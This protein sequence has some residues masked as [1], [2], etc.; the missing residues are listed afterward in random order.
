[1]TKAGEYWEED[2][3]ASFVDHSRDALIRSIDRSLALLGRIDVLQIHKA[4]RPVL[5]HPDVQAALDH[6]ASCGILAFGASVSDCDA[7]LA[8]VEAGRYETV[9]FPLNAANRTLLP[10]LPDLAR[11]S[12]LPVVNRPFAMGALVSGKSFDAAAFE[13]FAFLRA[14]VERGIVLTGTGKAAHLREN[15]RAFRSGMRA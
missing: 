3:R 8:A 14:H 10:L 13:A 1:M 6:A 4:T 2:G 15:V 11:T 12:V 5:G 9:Q 7:G